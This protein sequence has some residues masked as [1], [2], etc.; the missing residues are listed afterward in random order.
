MHLHLALIF[1]V[2]CGSSQAATY[3]GGVLLTNTVWSSA[4]SANPYYLTQDVQVPRNVTLTIQAGVVINFTQGDFEILV[5]GYLKVEGTA[6]Q[7]V[8]FQG[9]SGSDLK[10]ML[11]FQST[12]LPLTS[13][14]YAQ[15][16]GP[17]SAV[18]ITNSAPGL[19]QNTGKLVI[20]S[21]IFSDGTTISAN[22]IYP[23]AN[24][25]SVPSM[26]YIS[27]S[28]SQTT[29][30]S[31]NTD[32]EPIRILNSKIF[33]GIFSPLA[34]NEGIQIEN[35]TLRNI[36]VS[37]DRQVTGP[38]I[39]RLNT[40]DI[41][42]LTIFYSNTYYYSSNTLATFVVG[43]S[44]I[45][46]LNI[47][48]STSFSSFRPVEIILENSSIYNATTSYIS[49][50]YWYSYPPP[51]KISIRNCKFTLG[52]L[53][54]IM[55]YYDHSLSIVNSILTK[56]NITAPSKNDLG[57]NYLIK[58]FAMRNVSFT[59]GVIYLP[60]HQAQIVYSTITLRSPLTI[61]GTSTILC[62]S[63]GRSSSIVQA[64]SLG[65]DAAG[66]SLSRST[67]KNF[68]IGLRVRPVSVYAVNISQ[69]NFQSNT[70][71]NIDNKGTYDVLA[72]GNY[73]GTNNAATIT[74]KINDYWD[75]INYGEVFYNNFT[76]NPLAAET[77]CA[78][79]DENQY[80]T[81]TPPP[82]YWGK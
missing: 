76:A 48:I 28:F 80:T 29:V 67:I 39:F 42:N 37:Y 35:S 61:N 64:N 26:E 71:Y 52:N 16:K 79:F 8:T 51:P 4:G 60:Y 38:S 30:S 62:S 20:E 2:L 21:S 13:I 41:T 1:C 12:R 58:S 32:S 63:V 24:Y 81:T 3:V 82:Y 70:Q 40:S 5:K 78:A 53:T 10:Y 72:T 47:A 36:T 46:D 74:N 25:S 68:D 6:S 14:R 49:T 75:N 11:K 27:C 15:F 69:T 44:V 50:Y 66:L 7:K 65:V 45:R 77:G 54:L 34:S 33:Y 23:R 18:Q 43:Q 57:S 55:G 19:Q 56:V 73:W 22:G 59:D 31:I 17:K 9:G